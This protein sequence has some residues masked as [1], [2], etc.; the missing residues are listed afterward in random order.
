M[1]R[2]VKAHTP[3]GEDQLMFRSMHGT[4]GLSQLFEFEVDLLSPSAAIDMKA[5]L[6][7][8]LTLEIRTAGAP[9]FLNGQV[10]RF[11]M[12]GREG[13]TTSRHT[14]YR[15]TVR[16][17]L[18]YLTRTS[19]NK[20]F[21]NKSVIEVLDEVFAD[22]GFAF[23]KK[24]SG[25]Y[26]QWEYCVQYQETDF[27]F[28][29]RLMELEGIYYYFKHENGQHT[30][31]L[32]DDISAHEPT[33][34]YETINYFAA[35]R[36]LS[37]DTEV[38][39]RWEVVEEIRSG[40]YVV[41]DFDFT[42]PKADLSNVRNQPLS[43]DHADYEM[44]EWLGDYTDPGQGEHYARVRL[45]EA[46]AMAQ[47]SSGHATVRGMAPG[48]RFTMQN[49]PR[50]DDN[51]EYLTVAVS[52]S[53]REGGYATGAAPSDYGF[54][55][56]V[57][58][59]SVPFRP[60]RAMV[61]PRTSGPQ[62]ATVVGPPGEEIWTD[63]YGRVKV[64]FH[65]DRYGQRNEN[66]SRFVRVSHVIAGDGFGAVFTPRIGQEVV[67]DFI[68]GRPDRPIIVGRVYNAD[69]MPPFS[70]PGEATRSGF[71]TRSTPGGS[72]ATANSLV[73]ED[74][75]GAEF[76]ALHAERELNVSVE[77]NETHDTGGSR[78]TVITGHESATYKSGEERH[79]SK[80][81]VEEI[82]GGEHRT[83]TGGA[84]ET[85]SG[86]ELRT[87]SD[88]ATEHVTGGQ[89]R[90]ITGGL[91]ETTNG[92]VKKTIVGNVTEDTTGTVTLTTTGPVNETVTG[93]WTRKV[94][95]ASQDTHQSTLTETITGDH[96]STVTGGDYIGKA[97]NLRIDAT[98]GN[99]DITAPATITIKGTH[100]YLK[101]SAFQWD[102]SP[103]K[104]ASAWLSVTTN[105][106]TS[107]SSI[108]ANANNATALNLSGVGF[109]LFGAKESLGA[110]SSTQSAFKEDNWGADINTFGLASRIGMLFNVF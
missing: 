67:V 61:M 55:F 6:G 22:Y 84:T 50:G 87:I 69:Q 31:V 41:D 10:V 58:P 40:G 102:Y 91:T 14:V 98:A 18:W 95:Q 62:T 103:V 88:G 63:Q 60:A 53:L 108:L 83:V 77:A 47:R 13:G 101:H 57:Q 1:E 17:W 105:G 29:C 44:Y 8:P 78:T 74:K 66:S 106:V 9:R 64:Q 26:R 4:E 43:N 76:V 12:I 70:L 39:D 104:G 86:S 23:E 38:I 32:A 59:A 109:E 110:F 36:D 7:K 68:S 15:A 107:S 49:S 46:Q 28:V 2:V 5:V 54:S 21:Q 80:G 51:Q 75:M 25:S 73:F 33:P 71:V 20:I 65:W 24:L 92:I 85:V 16:P 11:S 82:D 72:P 27:A 90:T 99:I 35:D 34:D 42:K 19:D 97:R 81:A 89:L 37:E 100:L 45:E 48:Y 94:T 79:I 3:L 30:L 96:T 52:Y 93:T 56:V